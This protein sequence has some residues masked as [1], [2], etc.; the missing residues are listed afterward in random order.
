MV[1]GVLTFTT[2]AIAGYSS[3]VAQS[4][5]KTPKTI[6]VAADGSGQYKTV[7]EAVNAA[8]DNSA[9]PFVI[10]IKAGK[11]ESNVIVPK[12][13]PNITFQGEGAGKTL[14]SWSG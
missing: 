10:H 3:P 13:K 8:P 12:N 2:F 5:A 6:T 14:L 9:V 7:Q 1:A 11:Y 4:V